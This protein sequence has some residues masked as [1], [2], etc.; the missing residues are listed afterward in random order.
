MSLHDAIL[1]LAASGHLALCL[2]SI[3]RA[4]KNPLALPLAL[5]TFDLFGW[6]FATFCNHQFPAAR[7][8]WRAIDVVFTSLTPALVLGLVLAFVGK[9]R[10]FRVLLLASYAFFSALAVSSGTAFFVS[11][12]SA[13]IES[14][15]WAFLFLAAWA[16]TFAIELWL[17]VV[18]LRRCADAEEQAR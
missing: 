11:W 13:W 12:G 18:H 3:S 10:R 1:L 7:E 6:T 16:P 5:L 9:T 4:G 2:A 8:T 15:A 17:L 14:R